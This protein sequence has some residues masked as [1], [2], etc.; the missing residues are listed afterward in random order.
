MHASYSMTK[1]KQ[2]CLYESLCITFITRRTEKRKAVKRSQTEWVSVDL[3]TIMKRNQWFWFLVEAMVSSLDQFALW[4]FYSSTSRNRLCQNIGQNGSILRGF[5]WSEILFSAQC[6]RPPRHYRTRIRSKDYDTVRS[7]TYQ[8]CVD[9]FF[10]V[11]PSLLLF[12]VRAA[13]HMLRA[14]PESLVKN[15]SEQKTYLRKRFQ[16][17]DVVYSC[18]PSR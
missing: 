18:V 12:C 9:L 16:S 3:K 8:R 15:V 10:F 7:I 6:R 4:K 14:Q 2:K 13:S 11:S 17:S 5:G 1:Q